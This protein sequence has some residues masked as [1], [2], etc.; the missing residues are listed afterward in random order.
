MR[1]QIRL[2]VASFLLLAALIGTWAALYW[3]ESLFTES[4]LVG[5]SCCVTEEDLPA[6]GT[7]ERI[8]SD[9]FRTFPGKHLPPLVFVSASVAIFAIKMAKTRAKQWLPLLFIILNL[10]YLVAD[11]WLVGVS[12]SL[13]DR[14]NGPQT[15]PYKSYSRT[16][17][18]IALH[19]ALWFAYFAISKAN[20][21]RLLRTDPVP[22]GG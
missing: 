22:I 1:S 3:S 20:I 12:W 17:Y 18:G 6:R 10:L 19:I 4:H 2:A 14:L 8:A 13:S 5:Y 11:F 7:P 21:C 9:F 15:I 16:G